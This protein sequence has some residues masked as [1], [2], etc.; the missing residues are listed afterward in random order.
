[1]T[2]IWHVIAPWLQFL[3]NALSSVFWG[4]L[5]GFGT[6]YWLKKRDENRS[7]RAVR[8]QLV[9]LLRAAKAA[10]GGPAQGSGARTQTDVAI[11]ALCARAFAPDVA[12][13]LSPGEIQQIQNAA[14]SAKR[15]SDGIRDILARASPPVNDKWLIELSFPARTMIDAALKTLDAA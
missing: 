3:G 13:A 10:V 8:S 6:S 14:I 7:T 1:V 15:A 2:D 12:L 9:G 4:G 11:E 5:A